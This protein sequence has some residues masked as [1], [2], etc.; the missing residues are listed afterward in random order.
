MSVTDLHSLA[1]GIAS[2]N[3]SGEIIEVYYPKPLLNPSTTCAEQ[4]LA[5]CQDISDNGFIETSPDAMRSLASAL[6]EAMKLSRAKLR[7]R[8][9]EV[10]R[11]R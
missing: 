2:K 4:M 9:P 6:A 11:L 3:S 8:L 1:L 5:Q 10:Q 7:R